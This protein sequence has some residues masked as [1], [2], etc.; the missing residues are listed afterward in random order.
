M[1]LQYRDLE[2]SLFD[3]YIPAALRLQMR[4]FTHPPR[5]HSSQDLHHHNKYEPSDTLNVH[6]GIK[7]PTP[8]FGART[9]TLSLLSI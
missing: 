7:K 9:Y 5:L 8:S 6:T 1:T 4:M 3:N 2:Y